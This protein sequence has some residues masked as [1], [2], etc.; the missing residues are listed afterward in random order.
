M[1]S[2][3]AKYKHRWRVFK[4]GVLRKRFGPKKQKVT[5][6]EKTA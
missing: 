5:G 4:N 3:I 1:W 6:L 2:V